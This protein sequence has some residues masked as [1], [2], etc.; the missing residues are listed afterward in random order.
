M[1]FSSP[2]R[3]T[4]W[5]SI[6]IYWNCI[7][8]SWPSKPKGN[9]TY[10]ISGWIGF[11]LDDEPKHCHGKISPLTMYYVLIHV[12]MI[13][14]ERCFLQIWVIWGVSF[15][16]EIYGDMFMQ[17]YLFQILTHR[18]LHLHLPL[19]M[20]VFHINIIYTRYVHVYHLIFLFICSH[21]QKTCFP[22]R[23]IQEKR[24]PGP[25]FDRQPR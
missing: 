18:Y 1:V 10:I 22:I 8:S 25:L 16:I 9:N 6:P 20:H 3:T 15:N 13:Q 14:W 21:A 19:I 17:L 23:F 4:I 24:H 12:K 5:E 11:Q 2:S 7:Q